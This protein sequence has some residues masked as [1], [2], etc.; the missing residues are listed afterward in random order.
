[1][2]ST[3][4]ADLAPLLEPWN[5]GEPTDIERLGGS[6]NAS[7]RVTTPAGSHVLRLYRNTGNL[8]HVEHEH[9]LLQRLA[10]VPLSFGVPLPLLSRN[11]RTLEPVTLDS[12]PQFASVFNVIPGEHP[13][14]WANARRVRAAGEALGELDKALAGVVMP[15]GAAWLP[16]YGDPDRIHAA[17]TNPEAEI[18]NLPID[19]LLKRPFLLFLD[20]SRATATGLYVTLPR[21]IIHSDL[22][23]SNVLYL[24]DRVSGILDFEFALPDVR[25]MDLA[26]AVVQIAASPELGELDLAILR[27]L[28]AGYGTAV[29]LTSPEIEAVPALLCLRGAISVIHRLGRWKLG[30]SPIGAVEGR[31]RHNLALGRWLAEHGPEVIEALAAA[32]S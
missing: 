1:V 15:S 13:S 26:I 8:P 27:T 25:A 22:D 30:L 18:A 24:Q 5:L 7:W 31:I 32:S 10:G 4:P 11:G 3:D 17:V 12:R 16:S 20:R 14:D 9:T 29:R 19:P 23:G 28:A 21:Q 6:N 2:S